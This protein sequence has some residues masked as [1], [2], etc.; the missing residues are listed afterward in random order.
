MFRLYKKMKLLIPELKPFN[1]AK[2]GAI[3]ERVQ[4]AKLDL[5]MAQRHLLTNPGNNESIQ[6]ERI[7]L[8][9]CF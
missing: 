3:S 4:A 6:K 5:D 2:Y 7:C 1:K 8:N 9:Q